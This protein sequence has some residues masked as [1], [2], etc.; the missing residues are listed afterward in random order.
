MTAT[1]PTGV[2]RVTTTRRRMVVGLWVATAVLATLLTA[3]GAAGAQTITFSEIERRDQLIAAQQTLINIYRCRFEIDDS[4][5]PGGC[6]NGSPV[7]PANQPIPFD[8]IPTIDEITER[9]R[10]ISTNRKILSLYRCAL[11]IDVHLVPRGCRDRWPVPPSMEADPPTAETELSSVEVYEQIGPSIALI[12]TQSKK[13]SGVLIEGGYIVTNHH[14]VSPYDEA[15]VVFPDGTELEDV[16]VLAWDFMADLAVLGPVDVEFSPVRLGQHENLPPGSEVLLLGYPSEPE[17][18]PQPT[19]TRG[20]LSRTRQWDAYSLTLLQTDAAIAGG[21]S[22]GALLNSRGEVVGI[23][24]W[25]FSEAGFALATSVADNLPIIETLIVESLISH[26]SPSQR[27]SRRAP[28]AVGD[29]AHNVSG[30]QGLDSPAFTFKASAGTKVSVALNGLQDGVLTIS[31]SVRTIAVQD[32]NETG[33]ERTTFETVRDGIHFVSVGSKSEGRFAFEL[34]SS[35]RL[36]PYND[37]TDGTALAAETNRESF[38]GHFDHPGDI[39]WYKIDLSEDETIEI[40]TS[41]IIADTAIAVRNPETGDLVRSDGTDPLTGLGFATNAQLIFTA[42]TSG[43]YHIYVEETSN[44]SSQG[45]ALIV[46]RL[47]Q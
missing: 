26:Y 14:V 33:V 30:V 4:Q 9:D 20:I 18:F 29:F 7:E 3:T 32:G 15:W 44:R 36:D 25:R 27:S 28:K 22:G 38:Y 5:V 34:T 41:A 35:V 42:P 23:S 47:T 17:L 39:D 13:G 6:Y 21:Q 40:N 10:Q 16:P 46:E 11:N 8:G 1:H 31:D 37:P 12:E 45:Y 43:T 19:I 2:T 24:T